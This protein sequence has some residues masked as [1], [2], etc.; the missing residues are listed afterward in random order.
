MLQWNGTSVKTETTRRDSPVHQKEKE[1]KTH[2]SLLTDLAPIRMIR[3]ERK[4]AV[5][6]RSKLILVKNVYRPKKKRS[7]F[8]LDKCQILRGRHHSTQQGHHMNVHLT[9]VPHSPNSRTEAL[10]RLNHLNDAVA[11]RLLCC[12]STKCCIRDSRILH[13]LEYGGLP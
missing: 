13:F 5:R 6:V 8:V 1:K 4:P 9:P 7:Y 2:I 11:N 3:G 10:M 12:Q